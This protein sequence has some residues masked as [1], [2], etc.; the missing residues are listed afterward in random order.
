MDL[1]FHDEE[2]KNWWGYIYIL[3]YIQKKAPLIML[4]KRN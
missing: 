3:L 1:G 4:Q 2:R